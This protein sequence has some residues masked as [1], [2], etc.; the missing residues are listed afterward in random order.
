[1]NSEFDLLTSAFDLK[2]EDFEVINRN[3]LGSSFAEKLRVEQSPAGQPV[4]LVTGGSRK[5]RIGAAIA[6]TLAQEGWD[7]ATTFWRPYDASMPWGSNPEEAESILNDLR[8][9][10]ART[11]SIEADLSQPDSPTGIFDVVEQSLN[12]VTALVM[13]HCQSVDSNIFPFLRAKLSVGWE[14]G[15][16]G[17]RTRRSPHPL[18]S[19]PCVAAD[20]YYNADLRVRSAFQS[21]LKTAIA[22]RT[23]SGTAGTL[24]AKGQDRESVH[25][26]EAGHRR[27]HLLVA[28]GG[29]NGRLCTF[30]P[31]K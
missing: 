13:A 6:S 22:K 18:R 1:M 28:S 16:E 17:R 21:V 4:A 8:G 12:P 5:V 29:H 30:R 25:K 27:D 7:I 11:V 31:H 14:F 10:G 23:Q 20:Q 26:S 9:F 15:D 3:S 24:T 19:A 2:E